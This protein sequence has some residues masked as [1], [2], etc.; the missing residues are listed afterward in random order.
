LR[1]ASLRVSLFGQGI[2]VVWV[3]QQRDALDVRNQLVQKLDSLGSKY[4]RS[5]HY[6]GDMAARPVETCHQSEADR[7]TAYGEDNWDRRTCVP[8]SARR[9]HVSGRCDGGHTLRHQLG[10]ERRQGLIVTVRP[11]FL[12]ADILTFVETGLLQTLAK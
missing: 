4:V 7:I 11:P 3:H 2:E 8:S 12:N 6:S 1:C 10:R 5:E 9:G